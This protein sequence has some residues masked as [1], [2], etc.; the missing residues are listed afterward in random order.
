ML[1]HCGTEENR[2][3]CRFI[4]VFEN[5]TGHSK[6]LMCNEIL[7]NAKLALHNVIENSEY[8]EISSFCDAKGRLVH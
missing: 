5:V 8:A 4:E 7:S 2:Y 1:F 3:W 6:A